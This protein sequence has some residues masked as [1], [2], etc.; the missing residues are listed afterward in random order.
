[1]HKADLRPSDAL[2][3]SFAMRRVQ[4]VLLVNSTELRFSI[5]EKIKVTAEFIVVSS[6][7]LESRWF[8]MQL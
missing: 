2:N 6:R 4:R 3:H 8:L 7:E 1:M 5:S